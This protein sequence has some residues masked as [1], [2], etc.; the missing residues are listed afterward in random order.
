MNL[1]NSQEIEDQKWLEKV[2]DIKNKRDIIDNRLSDEAQL[3]WYKE[4]F[5]C[6][7]D[8]AEE[9]RELKTFEFFLDKKIKEIEEN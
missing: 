7:L 3:D 8:C 5:D 2:T 1:I 4:L 9:S 6:I